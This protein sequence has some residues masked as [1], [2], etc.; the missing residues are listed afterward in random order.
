MKQIVV[1]DRP[2]KYWNE[3]DSKYL[4]FCTLLGLF[5]GALVSLHL[6]TFLL[7]L[8]GELMFLIGP[9]GSFAL[10][11]WYV[12][13]TGS[14]CAYKAYLIAI[15]NSY[16][17]SIKSAIQCQYPW[18]VGY[19]L[20]KTIDQMNA[21][22]I[23][24]LPTKRN[25]SYPDGS[26]EIIGYP[27][28]SKLKAA[29]MLAREVSRN[30]ED[31]TRLGGVSAQIQAVE[32]I[33]RLI[34][35]EVVWIAGMSPDYKRIDKLYWYSYTEEDCKNGLGRDLPTIS[36][37]PNSE[38]GDPRQQ[39]EFKT[40]SLATNNSRPVITFDQFLESHPSVRE[41]LPFEEQELEYRRYLQLS[42]ASKPSNN[43]ALKAFQDRGQTASQ[44]D[45]DSDVW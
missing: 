18:G 36:T 42:S 26:S 31:I 10:A 8:P 45:E 6:L 27:D 14:Q 20:E 24:Y 3:D 19:I 37:P 21:V 40:I 25:Q 7:H 22:G 17:W 15:A 16:L 39:S 44:L 2:R 33:H 34:E 30:W 32:A 28:Q 13:V 4:I 12:S 29:V 11:Y 35:S 43:H 23:T 1:P 5:G 38:I 9:L 41:F